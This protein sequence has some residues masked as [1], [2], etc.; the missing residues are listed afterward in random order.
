MSTPKMLLSGGVVAGP[1]FTRP[2]LSNVNWI[3]RRRQLELP[4]GLPKPN[5]A[6]GHL[7]VKQSSFSER[8]GHARGSDRVWWKIRNADTLGSLPARFSTSPM[9]RSP[10][11]PRQLQPR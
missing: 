7:A 4:L 1:V 3:G 6:F 9:V 10:Q 2:S 5:Q 11:R 8:G